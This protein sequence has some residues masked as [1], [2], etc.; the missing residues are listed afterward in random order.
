MRSMKRWARFGAAFILFIYALSPSPLLSQSSAWPQRTVKFIVPLGPGS[1]VDITARMFADRLSKKWAQPVVVENRPGGDAIVAI[2]AFLGAADDHTLLFTPTSAFTSHPYLH[3]NLP[4]DPQDLGPIARVT[5]TLVVLAVPVA[6]NVGTVKELLDMA[7]AAPG[8]LNWAAATGTN[9]FLFDGFLKESG[10]TM[11]KVPYRDTV[12]ALNDLAEG[13]IEVYVGAYAIVR[14]HVQNGKVKVL[15]ITNRERASSVPDLPTV[16]EAG[17]PGLGFD[18]LVGLFGPRN[19]PTDL[20]ERIAGDI[21]TAAADPEV[22]ARLTATGQ[23][24]SPGSSAEF[25]AATEEQRTQVAAVGRALGMK[26][27]K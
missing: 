13:R 20:R 4:Y 27:S 11:T 7:R 8:K 23:V 24:I 2:T 9:E 21:R 14:P 15:A 6:L 26:P 17:F 12:Q 1:G 22:I 16:R 3:D 5:N 19:M 18:G 10:L 25:T